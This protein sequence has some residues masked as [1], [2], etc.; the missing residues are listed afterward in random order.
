[1]PLCSCGVIPAALGLKRDGASNG[2]TMGFLISTPQTGVD[3]ILVSASFLGLPFAIFK[4]LSALITGVLGGLL[5]NFYEKRKTRERLN[6]ALLP[7]SPQLASLVFPSPR[8]EERGLRGEERSPLSASERGLGGEVTR[9]KIKSLLEFSIN[10]LMRT[11]YGWVLFGIAAAA[12]IE[13]AVPPGGLS[14]TFGSHGLLSMLGMLLIAMPLYVCATGSVPIAASLINAGMPLG[15]ALVFLMAGPATNSAT[16]GAVYKTFGKAVTAI[17][18]LVVAVMSIIFGLFF[19]WVLPSSIAHLDHVHQ[20]GTNWIALISSTILFAL[21]AYFIW[22]D[23]RT[24]L[25]K[26]LKK[27]IEEEK[28]QLT[29]SIKG[30]TCQNCVRHV[31]NALA[32]QPGV[33]S[34]EVDLEAGRA[35]VS[36]DAI[37]AEK[38]AKAVAAAGYSAQPAK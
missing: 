16:L 12:M 24:L 7:S 19:D 34:V 26:K 15:S 3:S 32:A 21:F 2:A 27:G 8:H 29:L 17:Y 10:D 14:T 37:D 1:M 4:V 35:L 9:L 33:Q 20:H 11:I 38:L 5:V 31:K 30:M 28:M 13:I 6:N 23:L 18:V 36:G 25:A 22:S